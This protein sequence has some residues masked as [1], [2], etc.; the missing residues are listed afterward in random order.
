MV[1]VTHG[2]LGDGRTVDLGVSVA[3]AIS[4]AG[5]GEGY[6]AADRY[7]CHGRPM[8]KGFTRQ[9]PDPTT[10]THAVYDENERAAASAAAAA[11]AATLEEENA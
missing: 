9:V 2:H 5:Y 3:G 1:I 11:L 4:P 10:T 7:R 6:A 8:L